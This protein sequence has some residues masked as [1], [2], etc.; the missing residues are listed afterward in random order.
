MARSGSWAIDKKKGTQF[1]C[2]GEPAAA[3]SS[4]PGGSF[5]DAGVFVWGLRACAPRLLTCWEES[6][7]E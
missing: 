4:G 5:C 1:S 7:L 3:F 6:E 2:G